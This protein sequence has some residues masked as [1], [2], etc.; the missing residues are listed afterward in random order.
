MESLS[1]FYHQ[2]QL[3]HSFNYKKDYKL[4]QP[5][6]KMELAMSFLKGNFYRV[7]VKQTFTR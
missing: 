5:K 1:K 4:N 3:I 2:N 7:Y 6:Y